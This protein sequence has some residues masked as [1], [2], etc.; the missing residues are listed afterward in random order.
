MIQ[1]IW[2]QAAN[3][4]NGIPHSG[5]NTFAF[6]SFFLFCLASLPALY[7]PVHQI[8]HLFTVK[9]Y[10]VPI[11]G[12][13]FLIW[14]IKKAGGIGPIVHQPSKLHGSALAWAV[15]DMLMSCVENF[16]TLVV[17]DPDFTRFARK[18]SD[19]VWSQILAIPFSFAITSFIGIIVS[20][21]S[22]VIYGE[23]IWSPLQVLGNFL[24]GNH[25]GARAGVFFISAVFALAQV[26]CNIAANAIS[27]GTDMTALFPR[28]INIRR[29][30]F[31]C[32]TIGFAM[33]PWRL[34][35]TS[36]KFTTYL[37]AYTV[38]LSAIAGVIFCD[39]YLVRKGKLVI[40][41]LYSA[42][43]SG[44]YYFFKG[45]SWRAYAA[46]ICG[47]AINITG[48]VG[49]VG[50]KVPIGATRVYELNFFGG[51]IVS[52]GTYYLFC[53]LSPVPGC[54]EKWDESEARIYDA[55]HYVE[56]VTVDDA[57]SLPSGIVDDEDP[58]SKRGF[59]TLK[60]RFLGSV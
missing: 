10:L 33:C 56:G 3:I 1:S 30:G 7:F 20:S 24:E 2:P 39:Y 17:N 23:T 52:A 53:R 29:G 13:A 40:D 21:S 48:M 9:S 55:I 43:P 22:T 18:P 4:P 38:F 19:A 44:I 25:S 27:A 31:I 5:T 6:M 12:I 28:Y 49:A 35:E 34:L 42:D 54:P 46:Y 32:A 16:V 8:R 57:S 14:T 36:N 50:R 60:Q 51:F 47:V 26:G 41:D 45:F 11:A 37:S 15:I 59:S 58:D